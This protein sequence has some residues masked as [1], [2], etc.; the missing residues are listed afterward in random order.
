LMSTERVEFSVDPKVYAKSLRK[1]QKLMKLVGK[2]KG[3]QALLNKLN[4]GP[5]ETWAFPLVD[6]WKANKVEL[7]SKG[8][9][10]EKLQCELLEMQKNSDGNLSM[11][12]EIVSRPMKLSPVNKSPYAPLDAPDLTPRKHCEENV[13]FS[14]EE[15]QEYTESDSLGKQPDVALEKIKVDVKK[16]MKL[17]NDSPSSW[18]RKSSYPFRRQQYVLRQ[19]ADIMEFDLT[20]K[21]FRS[22]GLME[23]T[24]LMSPY[25][26][27][28]ESPF[29][30]TS[31]S[32][33][34]KKQPEKKATMGEVAKLALKRASQSS[35]MESVLISSPVEKIYSEVA[36]LPS[37]KTMNRPKGKKKIEM[38]T[39]G[40]MQFSTVKSK[41]KKKKSENMR[42]WLPKMK[43]LA[44]KNLKA[45]RAEVPLKKKKE[46]AEAAGRGEAAGA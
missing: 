38:K 5:P 39:T 4:D 21:V 33:R 7:A 1:H 27:R 40:M 42:K 36:I 20:P 13:E 16:E 10:I 6:R 43:P 26:P 34:P 19:E 22:K 14:M 46:S 24:M 41:A 15:H 9:E 45:S 3:E 30:A 25:R 23:P 11:K 8:I 18:K 35:Q 29:R 37:F 32:R 44:G 31:P 17:T 12:I 2:L 28:R